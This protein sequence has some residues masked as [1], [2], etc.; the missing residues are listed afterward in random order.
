MSDAHEPFT[1]IDTAWLRM[2]EP[3]SPMVITAVLLLEGTVESDVLERLVRDKLLPH[4]RFSLRVHDPRM[5]GASPRWERDP[6]FDLRNHVHRIGLPAPRDRG[7]LVSLVA[8]LA[9]QRLER[10]RPL[11]QLYV[12][13]GVELEG[14]EATALVV[15]LH[16]CIGDGVALVGLLLSLTDEGVA[17]RPPTPGH[18]RHAEGAFGLAKEAARQ[19]ATLARLLLL[20]RDP[21]TPYKGELGLV[22]RLAWSAPISLE[23]VRAVAARIE[24]KV[25][26][27]LMAC[28]AGAMRR[29]LLERGWDG[30]REIRTL[31][32]VHIPGGRGADG[33]GN[34]I[35]LVFVEMPVALADREARLRETKARMDRVK[36]QPDATV[37]LAVL[38]AM[39]A[40][41]HEVEHFGVSLFASKATALVTNVA[42][43]LEEVHFA[44]HRVRDVLLWAP[45]SGGIGLGF[46]LLSYAG[47]VRLGV[48]GD[49]KRIEDPSV[50]V[51]AFEEELEALGAGG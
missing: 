31:V 7:A 17:L 10:A 13:D 28:I 1:T 43:P 3:T 30:V 49:A 16:H 42:G 22:K 2:D 12:V 11:W 44:G 50:L 26:D 18:L 14:R 40:A 51:R 29:D 27:V 15:R 37:A 25:N 48:L 6:F 23:R 47:T 9:S 24:G 32:P 4:A 41:S 45:V 5:P 21:E 46:S 35:G 20:P 34:H 33:L 8:D 36:E 39:G 19:T 38:A